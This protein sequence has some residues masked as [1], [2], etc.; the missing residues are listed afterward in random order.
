MFSSRDYCVWFCNLCKLLVTRM[1]SVC[2]D[3]GSL[4]KGSDRGAFQRPSAAPRHR[5]E[6]RS[7]SGDEYL[8]FTGIC[9]LRLPMWFIVTLFLE[10]SP[11]CQRT[12]VGP[13][14][15]TTSCCWI[16]EPGNIL[17]MFYNLRNSR[18]FVKLNLFMSLWVLHAELLIRS[19]L[20]STWCGTGVCRI[21]QP[22]F[23]KV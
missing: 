15:R 7:G 5:P 14:K 16:P 6:C 3:D 20:L 18:V 8:M 21:T 22:V 1:W 2:S 10:S 19:D 4:E 9:H 11:L 23:Q 12:D 17:K 13:N